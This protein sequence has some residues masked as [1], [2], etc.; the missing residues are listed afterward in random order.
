MKTRYKILSVIGIAAVLAWAGFVFLPWKSTLEREMEDYLE[1]RGLQDVELTLSEVSPYSAVFQDISIG[2]GQP[3]TIKS[4]TVPY[5]WQAREMSLKA[6]ALQFSKGDLK[7]QAAA[8]EAQTKDRK[9]DWRLDGLLVET[10]SIA[11]P[12][13]AGKGAVDFS[14]NTFALSGK[15]GSASNAHHAAFS[16]DYPFARAEDATLVVSSAAMP[17]KGGTLTTENVKILLDGSQPVKMVLRIRKASADAL[18]QA[19]TGKRVSATGTLSGRLPLEIAQDGAVT[20]GEGTLQAD[21]AGVVAL[22]P[23]AIPGDDNEKVAMVRDILKNFHYNTLSLAVRNAGADGV[24]LLVTLDG[25]N[26]DMYNGRNIK[27]NV[28]LTGDVLD[29]VRQNVLFLTSPEKMLQ[30]ERK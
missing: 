16:I 14:G 18:L 28:R 20:F 27:L 2:D 10:G 15:I 8:A 3:F 7:I 19:L 30:Q 9:G 1:A 13:M 6:V 29:Y 5:S 4:L 26:P 21:E 25:K 17:W 12:P 23:D 24:I 22:P 11:L